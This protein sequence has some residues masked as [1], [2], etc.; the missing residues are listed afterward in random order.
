MTILVTV[1]VIGV[2]IFVH[3]LGHFFA[4]KA[5]GVQ[6]LRFSL[7]FGQPIVTWRRGETDYWISWLPIGGYVKMAGLEDEGLEKLEGTSA[8]PIDPARAF[9]RK[10]IWRRLVILAA[11][12][13]MN[14]VLAL[15]IF[16]GIAT[17]AGVPELAVTRVDSVNVAALPP[18]ARSL[19]V[20]THGD[21][22]ERLSDAPIRSWDAF[23]TAVL[24]GPADFRVEAAG[25][26]PITVH[27]SSA[28]ERRAVLEAIIPLIP[29]RLAVV[30]PGLPAY[31]GGLRPGDLVIRAAR[32]TVRSW[33]DLLRAIRSHPLLPLPLEVRR[34]DTSIAVTVIPEARRD[35]VAGRPVTV[36]FI[37]AFND[38]PTLYTRVPFAEGLRVGVVQTERQVGAILGVFGQI[39][40]GRF[41]L[42]DLGGPILIGQISGQA[43]RLGVLDWLLPFVAIFSI[44]LAILNLLPIPLLDG[45]Q[46]VFVLAEAVRRRPLSRDLRL[47]LSQIGLVILVGIMLFAIGNDLVRNLLH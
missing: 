38:R 44:N 1:L 6:V 27:L 13:T 40:Q 31:R 15:A 22:L 42:R 21:S 10:P 34:G 25:R 16:V 8:T 33:S 4:A 24:T 32:D 43:A 30:Q 17:T 45:G 5:L 2:L 14:I 9:D 36:G 26:P 3:E 19:A 39:V 23:A 28:A 35:T 47:R 29:A 18:G 7:G 12:V 20:L 46:I 37:G 11:G 41:S